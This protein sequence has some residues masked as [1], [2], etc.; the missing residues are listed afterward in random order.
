VDEVIEH[1]PGLRSLELR[2]DRPVPRFKPGQFLQLAIDPWDPSTHWPDS[3]AFSI[4]SAP[5]QRDRL[6]LTFSAVG[7]FTKRM[8]ALAPGSAVWIKLPYGDFVVESRADTPAVLVA[9]GTGITPFVSFLAANAAPASEVR[10]VYGVRRPD[11]AVYAALLA[12]AGRRHP[13][14]R[15]RTFVEEG[16]D[17]TTTPGRIDVG[18]VLAEG[19][20]TAAP[21]RAIY[22]LAGPPAM[23][24][25][26]R[27]GL[28]A[29]SVDAERIRIDAWS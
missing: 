23:I 2:T 10:V 17:V 18:C 16:G 14:I 19:A 15:C 4:A 11:L 9:G 28:L 20:S 24:E 22:Y 5:E 1:A 12:E 8:L 21:G 6:R 29:G 7:V 26:L 25:T 3:R 13:N 27:S